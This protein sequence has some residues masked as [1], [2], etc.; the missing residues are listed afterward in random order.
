MKVPVRYQFN[1]EMP[2]RGVIKWL[3][4]RTVRV[5]LSR[6]RRNPLAD[7][8]CWTGGTDPRTEGKKAFFSRQRLSK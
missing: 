4:S 7:Q 3:N 2:E 1:N 8:C 6:K 5:A